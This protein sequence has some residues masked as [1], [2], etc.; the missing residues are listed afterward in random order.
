MVATMTSKLLVK[1]L[2]LINPACISWWD[3]NT[4]IVSDP[5]KSTYLTVRNSIT[6]RFPSFLLGYTMYL[7]TMFSEDICL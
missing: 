3:V 6:R 2:A 5:L 4:M 7:M 1:S